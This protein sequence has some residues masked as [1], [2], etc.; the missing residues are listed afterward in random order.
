AGTRCARRHGHGDPVAWMDKKGLRRW[1]WEV[2][3]W[4][5]RRCGYHRLPGL[6]RP[7][8]S[9][10]VAVHSDGTRRKGDSADI[11]VPGV[12]LAG[13]ELPSPDRLVGS[14]GEGVVYVDVARVTEGR[15]IL[16]EFQNIRPRC[17]ADYEAPPGWTSSIEQE[18]TGS[19]DL[20]RRVPASHDRA[21]PRQRRDCAGQLGGDGVGTGG[22]RAAN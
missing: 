3:H 11:D 5:G 16:L 20:E 22:R 2:Y 4:I 19:I 18:H 9:R 7:T 13:S 6:G 17:H 8:Q 21:R 15:Q 12:Q 10:H 14:P 1:H